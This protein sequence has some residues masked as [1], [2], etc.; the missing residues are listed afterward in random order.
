MRAKPLIGENGNVLV[1]WKLGSVGEWNMLLERAQFYDGLIDDNH[2]LKHALENEKRATAPLREEILELKAAGRDK[3][4]E[5]QLSQ[6][7]IDKLT[8]EVDTLESEVSALRERLGV[9]EEREKEERR[10]DDAIST[11]RD[12]YLAEPENQ[13]E[14]MVTNYE[15]KYD[16][17]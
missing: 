11:M 2:E 6:N 8:L 15:G 4:S 1:S 3:D 12:E 16:D 9:N 17:R 7:E 5:L 14:R 10:I 13:G